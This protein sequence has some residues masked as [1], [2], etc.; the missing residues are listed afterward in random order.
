MGE[1]CDEDRRHIDEMGEVP[2]PERLS[3]MM[4]SLVSPRHWTL[5]RARSAPACSRSA[6]T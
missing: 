1:L 3:K 6:S 5:E 2:P 4:T